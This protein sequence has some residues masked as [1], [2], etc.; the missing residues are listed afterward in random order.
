MVSFNS[1]LSNKPPINTRQKLNS[2]GGPALGNGY[3]S[4]LGSRTIDYDIGESASQVGAGERQNS[5]HKRNDSSNG[6][7][8]ATLKK[9][10]KDAR[11]NRGSLIES[12]KG[13]NEDQLQKISK[14]LKVKI[15]EDDEGS[16]A[17]EATASIIGDA[18]AEELNDK[19][20]ELQNALMYDQGMNDDAVSR[21]SSKLSYASMRLKADKGPLSQAGSSLT[22]L[23]QIQSLKQELEQEKNARLNLERELDELKKISTEINKHLSSIKP[24]QNVWPMPTAGVPLRH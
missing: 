2:Q 19:V 24:K 4:R 18:E 20:E 10:A 22:R 13:M 1:K 16:P 8:E 21:T 15:G 5:N 12:I 6:L 17:V 11:L 9:V 7:R 3:Q 23:S 14:F